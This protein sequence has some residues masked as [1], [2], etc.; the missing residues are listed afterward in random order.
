MTFLL[1]SPIVEFMGGGGYNGLDHPGLQVVRTCIMNNH[2]GRCIY[3]S[4][5][6]RTDK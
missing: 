1:K 5:D 4:Q 2:I 3:A 6:H